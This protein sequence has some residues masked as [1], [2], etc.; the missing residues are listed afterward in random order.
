MTLEGK[1]GKE[2]KE[3]EERIL[4]IRK[5]EPKSLYVM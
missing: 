3:G 2:E 5:S 1:R 4:V